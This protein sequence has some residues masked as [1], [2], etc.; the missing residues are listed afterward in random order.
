MI[1][2]E[3]IAENYELQIKDIVRL[4]LRIKTSISIALHA[5]RKTIISSS[6]CE[7]DTKKLRTNVYQNSCEIDKKVTEIIALR[8]PVASDLR[9]FISVLKISREMDYISSCSKK[10]AKTLNK[11]IESDSSLL[12]QEAIKMIDIC[13]E[14]MDRTFRTFLKNDLTKNHIG[15]AVQEELEQLIKMDD[16]IDTI[17]HSIAQDYIGKMQ[18]IKT[19]SIAISNALTVAKEIEKVGDFISSIAIDCKYAITG[20]RHQSL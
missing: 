4:I 16:E 8:H 9:F 17:Y 1:K 7:M 10:I 19:N 12:P 2:N 3:H 15:T 20:I 14:V 13:L 18:N 11:I 5:N 6:F